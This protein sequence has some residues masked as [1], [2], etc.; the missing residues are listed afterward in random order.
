MWRTAMLASALVRPSLL[1]TA[2]VPGGYG[3]GEGGG[4]G[5]DGGGG[6]GGGG[7][8]DGGGGDGG[9]GDGDGGGGDGDGDGGGGDGCGGGG[10][11]V[12]A[13]AK[14]TIMARKMM[15]ASR[16]ADPR[17]T[18]ELRRGAASRRARELTTQT[19]RG[20]GGGGEADVKAVV[21]APL[22]VGLRAPRTVCGDIQCVSLRDSIRRHF[23][24]PS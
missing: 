2:A 20:P 18:A 10:G 14:P 3:G 5:G 15:R 23:R 16:G 13:L 21:D 1:L 9:G 19:R 11:L 6:E 12:C 22:R 7:D 17:R 24:I 8:G 4:G